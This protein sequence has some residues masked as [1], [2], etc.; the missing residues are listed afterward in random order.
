MDYNSTRAAT[1]NLINQSIVWTIK[2]KEIVKTARR[3]IMSDQQ[4]NT[5]RYSG[6][7]V[8]QRKAAN[9]HKS[10]AQLMFRINNES[11]SSRH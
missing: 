9:S 2:C 6:Y 4:S 3:D 10:E 7:Q 5:Q 11:K 8:K 1:N